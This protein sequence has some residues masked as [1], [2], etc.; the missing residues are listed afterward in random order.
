LPDETLPELSYREL[1]EELLGVAV[2]ALDEPPEVAELPDVELLARW[3]CAA[4]A[5]NKPRLAAP[6]MTTAA[7]ANLARLRVSFMAQP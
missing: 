1:A 4:C 7:T 3:A 6:A 2:A 5:T